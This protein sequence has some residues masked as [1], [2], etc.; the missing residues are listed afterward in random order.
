MILTK[1]LNVASLITYEGDSFHLLFGSGC[2]GCL[3][4]WCKLY[5]SSLKLTLIKPFFSLMFH[6]RPQC[7][8]LPGSQWKAYF[9]SSAPLHCLSFGIVHDCF[10]LGISFLRFQYSLPLI[11]SFLCDYYP[12][13]IFIS[14]LMFNKHFF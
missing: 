5:W 11:V 8:I 4:T 1:T 13:I 12:S 14:P 7:L 2:L 3:T 6:T 10:N 9:W